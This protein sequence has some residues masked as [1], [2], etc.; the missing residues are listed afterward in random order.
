[1]LI[2]VILMR[3]K[4][5]SEFYYL[6]A[7]RSAFRALYNLTGYGWLYASEFERI[8]AHM[9]NNGCKLTVKWCH[10]ARV[11]A[12]ERLHHS[13]WYTCNAA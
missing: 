13:E 4:R 6:P 7:S 5:T 2:P 10:V 8:Q 1:M 9:R 11:P 12:D 3:A